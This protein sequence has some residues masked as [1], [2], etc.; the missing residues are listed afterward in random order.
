MNKKHRTP[1]KA[2]QPFDYRR[3][4]EKSLGSFGIQI[5]RFRYI[6]LFLIVLAVGFLSIYIPKIN[7]A[8]SLES[9]FKGHNQAIQDYQKFRD[10]FGRDD[11]IVLLIKSEDIFSVHFLERLKKF[12]EDLEN[13][14]PLLS[15][16]NSLINARYIEG[17][18]GTLQVN[19]FLENLPQTKE[20]AQILRE[21][22]LVYPLFRNSYITQNGDSMIMVIKT[23]A[24]S[25]LTDDGSKIKNYGRGVADEDLS[26]NQAAKSI[27]Q[28]ENIAILGIMETVIKQYN[29]DNFR[30]IF[31]GT[32]A[33]QFHVEPIIRKNMITMSL[34]VLMLTFFF[35][36]ILFGRVSGIFLPQ[37]V[38]IMG[39]GATLG[40]M[41]L[42]EVPFTLTSSM[43][44]SILLSVGLTAPIHFMVVFFKY[45]KR[46]GRMRAIIRTLGHSGLPIIMTSLTTIVGLLSFSFTEIAPIAHLGIFA[47]IG[48]AICLVLTLV[49]LPA[50]LSILK[51]LPGKEREMLY[52]TSIYNRMLTWMGRTGIHH[53]HDIY[54]LSF[55]AFIIILPGFF[56]FNFSHNMLHYFSEDDPFIEQTILIEDET[57]GFR[58]LEVVIDTGKEKGILDH[59]FLNN[60]EELEDFALDQN[61]ISGRPYTGNIISILDIVKK[62]NQTWHGDDPGHHTIPQDD[63]LIERQ[64]TEFK[65]AE[66]DYLKNYTDQDFRLARFTA[67]MYWKDAALDVLFVKKLENFASRLF[68]KD[69]KVV[70]T[71]AV[72]INSKV[73][74]SM[75]GNLATGYFL[76]FFIIALFM[77]IAVGDVKLGLVA[78][79]PNMYPI[80]AGLGLMGLLDIPL[81]TYNLIGGSIVIGVAVDDTIHFFHNFRNYYIKTGD[82]EIAVN[83]TLRSAGRALITT[84]L[85]L[86]CCFWLRLFS[87]LK[88]IS[89]FG[90][91]MGFSLLVAFLADVMLAPALLNA[92]YGGSNTGSQNKAADAAGS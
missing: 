8:T 71:G 74:D 61:G 45:Q 54:I 5:I 72:S 33:Y 31:S 63:Y 47:A 69:V 60:L 58:A 28:V 56:K 83:E 81:N 50:L 44:P 7:I 57:S 88:V 90:L 39:L 41:A 3:K 35:M 34:M 65:Q 77:I 79:I 49:F 67:M 66:P 62:T 43:L 48:I 46:I 10:L 24:V 80:I 4:V 38:V 11:K 87:P 20:Q 21:K 12:H 30:I 59:A 84:T 22:A 78:M 23:Q 51:I 85:I 16:V 55:I 70:V 25:A 32:P 19:D 40:L 13:T 26:D 76:A 75:M 82:V 91:I 52:E 73:I 6:L 68:G 53:A 64:L 29:T 14:L 37:F 92:F 27:S 86:V 2:D 17:E 18:N 36:A 9:S 15:E 42:A 1:E 89:D